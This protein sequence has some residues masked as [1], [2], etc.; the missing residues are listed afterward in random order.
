M[1]GIGKAFEFSI[2]LWFMSAYLIL[3]LDAVGYKLRTMKKEARASRLIGWI[4]V[5]LGILA[6]IGSWFI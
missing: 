2:P 3:R 5:V 1:I 4:N 6:L